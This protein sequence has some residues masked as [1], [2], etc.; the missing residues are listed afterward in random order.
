MGGFCLSHGWLVPQGYDLKASEPIGHLPAVDSPLSN[1]G[2]SLFLE[3]GSL[4]PVICGIK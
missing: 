3:V 1:T 2:F 4:L